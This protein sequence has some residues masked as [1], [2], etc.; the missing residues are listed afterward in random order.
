MSQHA[1]EWIFFVVVLVLIVGILF[2]VIRMLK[3]DKTTAKATQSEQSIPQ[4]TASMK[5]STK[6]MKKTVF[7]PQKSYISEE[8]RRLRAEIRRAGQQAVASSYGEAQQSEI[9][10]GSKGVDGGDWNDIVKASYQKR[11]G[12]NPQA[13]KMQAPPTPSERQATEG[14]LLLYLMAPRSTEF[15]GQSVLYT[16]RR[17][18]LQLT[19]HHVFESHVAQEGTLYYVGSV[20]PPG[21]FDMDKM[22]DFSTPGLTFTIDLNDCPYPKQALNEMLKVV[23]EAQQRLGGDVLDDRRQRLNHASLS[24]YYARVKSEE[25]LRKA[26]VHA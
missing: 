17:Q 9:N 26:V 18:G 22:H 13:A 7:S 1:V 25:M 24:E 23:H 4:T 14:F 3:G 10:F 21:T 11:I 19:D 2:V 16:L 5:S 20:I 6:P 8:E 12:A 15:N